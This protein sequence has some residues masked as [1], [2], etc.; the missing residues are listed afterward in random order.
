MK[1]LALTTITILSLIT[2]TF[3]QEQDD[4]KERRNI[5][6]RFYYGGGI[7]FD[8]TSNGINI[9]ALPRV[10][11]KVT[12]NFSVGVG[13]TYQYISRDNLSVTNYGGNVFSRYNITQEIFAHAEYEYL[14]F[15]YYLPTRQK[16]RKGYNSMLVGGGYYKPFGGRA[17]ANVTVLYNLLYDP[18][19]V[20]QPYNSPLVIR[21][22]VSFGIFQ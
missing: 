22:G 12:N 2:G 20:N 4:Y 21:G 1:K 7:G 8:I 19:E 5:L 13:L 11:Y 6:D 9:S 17:A 16:T 18:N 14:N 10:G 3:A 15:Q